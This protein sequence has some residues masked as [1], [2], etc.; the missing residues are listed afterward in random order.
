MNARQSGRKPVLRH[1]VRLGTHAEKDCLFRA[2]QTFDGLILNANLVEATPGACASLIASLGKRYIIDPVTY[3]FAL[4][5]HHLMSPQSDGAGARILKPKRTFRN[6]AKRFGHP[7]EQN[8]GVRA[9]SP[10]SLTQ[11]DIDAVIESVLAYQLDRLQ[12]EWQG[13]KDL[14]GQEPPRAECLVAPY[15]PLPYQR[16]E[17][18]LN[19]NLAIARRAGPTRDSVPVYAVVCLDRRFLQGKE[20]KDMASKYA[21]TAVSGYLLWLG[22]LTEQSISR[23]ELDGYVELVKRLSSGGRRVFNMYGGYLSAVLRCFGMTG[24]AHGIGYGERR[25]IAPP[26]GGGPPPARFYFR[27]LHAL[28]P[29]VNAFSAISDLDAVTY[30]SEVCDCPVCHRVIGDDL[31]RNIVEYGTM[32]EPSGR[33]ARQYPTPRARKLCRLHYLAAR[34]REVQKVISQHPAELVEEMLQAESRY[35]H[36]ASLETD[37]LL[38]WAEGIRANL[39]LD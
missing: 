24:F 10:E 15:F 32:S 5:P 39:P 30:Y 7:F 13:A 19:L 3:A 21:N 9:L 17:P 37:H 38:I 1:F 27:P 16:K 8:L 2:S 28:Y 23:E 22:G 6:L 31:K 14:G 34:H 4:P 29:F 12:D 18:W 36:H 20:L 35:A 25:A 33:T 11:S 26:V